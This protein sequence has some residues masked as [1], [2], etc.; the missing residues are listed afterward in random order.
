[1][2]EDNLLQR[3][4]LD[5]GMDLQDVARRTCLSPTI[6]ARIDSGRW[7]EL[8]A[9]IYA[10]SY[11]RSFAAAVG[12]N[13]GAALA[14]CE[15]RLPRA[16][17]PVPALLA[18]PLPDPPAWGLLVTAWASGSSAWLRRA[19]ARPRRPSLQARMCDAFLL[20]GGYL[21]IVQLTSLVVR[22]PAPAVM[23]HP[24]V[25]LLWLFLVVL[26]F[27]L[28]GGL[29]GRTVGEMAVGT[30]SRPGTD[31][32]GQLRAVLQRAFLF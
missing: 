32:P 16:D 10:R 2:S 23:E 30:S 17:D 12:V 25:V 19:P 1:V 22:A 15:D 20:L 6:V 24:G 31:G 7:D 18:T 8:P 11:V 26:Y 29:G 13:P 3:A 4:R 28:L 27:L 5:R 14:A 9:G 21:A